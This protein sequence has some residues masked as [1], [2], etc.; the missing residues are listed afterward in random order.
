MNLLEMI[1]AEGTEELYRRTTYWHTKAQ[2][3]MPMH[4]DDGQYTEYILDLSIEIMLQYRS[5]VDGM[6]ETSGKSKTIW[7]FQWN[8]YRYR[9]PTLYMRAIKIEIKRFTANKTDYDGGAV[10]EIGSRHIFRAIQSTAANGYHGLVKIEQ[11]HTFSFIRKYL[12]T[13]SIHSVRPHSTYFGVEPTRWI[14]SSTF[15]IR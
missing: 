14:I 4:N 11:I 8:R 1:R 10:T 15:F 2:C 6:W 13:D 9:Q 5:D 3:T 12:R 7:T